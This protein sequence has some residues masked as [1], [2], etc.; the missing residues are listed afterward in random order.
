MHI[1]DEELSLLQED[2]GMEAAEMLIIGPEV[3]GLSPTKTVETATVV[4]RDGHL[5]CAK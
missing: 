4:Q 5:A 3:V 1:F 2:L